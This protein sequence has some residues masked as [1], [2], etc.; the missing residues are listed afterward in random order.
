M[1]SR[2]PRVPRFVQ[3][4]VRSPHSA[5]PFF[6]H[7]RSFIVSSNSTRSKYAY[8]ESIVFPPSQREILKGIYMYIH[9]IMNNDMISYRYL[10]ATFMCMRG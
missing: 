7:V 8:L 3:A 4:Y 6:F 1:V 2:P 9:V 10:M 5:P